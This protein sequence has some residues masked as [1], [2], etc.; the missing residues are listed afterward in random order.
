VQVLEVVQVLE[1]LLYRP[2]KPGIWGNVGK[3]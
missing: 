1:E 3:I 2:D